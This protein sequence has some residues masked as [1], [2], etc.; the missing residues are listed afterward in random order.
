MAIDSP[1]ARFLKP[2]PVISAKAGIKTRQALAE[3]ALDPR[4]RGVTTLN[5][6]YENRKMAGK[7]LER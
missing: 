5:G 2:D 6:L 4:S 3:K 7:G 1:A